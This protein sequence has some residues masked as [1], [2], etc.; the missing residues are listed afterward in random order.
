[1]ERSLRFERP[2][3]RPSRGAFPSP[4]PSISD[5]DDSRQSRLN[6]E[7][8][9]T[10]YHVGE[11]VVTQAVGAVRVAVVGLD[12]GFRLQEEGLTASLLRRIAIRLAV[13]RLYCQH[14]VMLIEPS[15][16]I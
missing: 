15:I 8:C 13:S 2:Q 3:E 6:V 12:L 14:C 5:R 10:R 9:I 1:M 4:L 7:D 16:V 11:M